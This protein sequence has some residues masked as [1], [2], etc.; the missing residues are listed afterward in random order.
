MLE[1]L[2]VARR[3]LREMVIMESL[4]LEE[5]SKIMKSDCQPITTMPAKPYPEVP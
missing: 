5:T 3:L 4:R 2:S 1:L